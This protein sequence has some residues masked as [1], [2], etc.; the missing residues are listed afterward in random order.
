MA[1]R[2]KWLM[3]TRYG[4]AGEA[5]YASKSFLIASTWRLQS[6]DTSFKVAMTIDGVLNCYSRCDYHRWSIRLFLTLRWPS[7]EYYT[8]LHVLMTANEVLDF[9]GSPDLLPRRICPK[10]AIFCLLSKTILTSDWAVLL[11]HS[12]ELRCNLP[13]THLSLERPILTLAVPLMM[14]TYLT[15]CSKFTLQYA[16]CKMLVRWYI[17][18]TMVLLM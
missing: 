10:D 9:C 15:W 14:S 1:L 16:L 4:F 8:V 17:M 3:R 18:C 2:V 6:M 12:W 13:S 7:M 11:V 5:N